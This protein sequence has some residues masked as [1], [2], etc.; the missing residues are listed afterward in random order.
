M[1]TSFTIRGSS[2]NVGIQYTIGPRNG[3]V[4]V[5]SG[6]WSTRETASVAVAAHGGAPES[7]RGVTSPGPYDL[8]DG[9]TVLDGAG[10]QTRW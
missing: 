3:K 4:L 2:T 8:M 9:V 10:T 1:F 6:C 7:N 5:Q